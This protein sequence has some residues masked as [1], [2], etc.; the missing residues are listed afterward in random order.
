M[1][2]AG[3]ND[4]S[5]VDEK[6]FTRQGQ[7]WGGPD[8]FGVETRNE[9]IPE[10]EAALLR[11]MLS[12]GSKPGDDEVVDAAGRSTPEHALHRAE[13]SM[14]SEISPEVERSLLKGIFESEG[15]DGHDPDDYELAPWYE[16]QLSRSGMLGSY[17]VPHHDSMAVIPGA[18]QEPGIGGEG[19]ELTP[20]AE[21]EQ[22]E[23][24]LPSGKEPID[25]EIVDMQREG[26]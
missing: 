22:L 23:K 17:E 5:A 12:E 11:S 2:S 10:P 24:I 15:L 1:G 4:G 3:S 13:R 8:T 14:V 25:H 7:R 26:G 9:L 21:R 16:A 6:A 19:R 20:D 18:H